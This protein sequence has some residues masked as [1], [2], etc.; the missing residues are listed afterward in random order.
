[1]IRHLYLHVPFCSGKC[2]YCGFYSVVRPPDERERY[3]AALVRELDHRATALSAPLTSLYLGGGTPALL[4]VGGF[5]CLATALRT[6]GL[7]EAS[8][9]WTVELHPGS[10]EPAFL[11]ALRAVGV[12]RISLGAQS[13]DD[14]VLRRLGRRHDAAAVDRA[15]GAVRQTGFSDYGLDLIAGLPGV[16]E[17]SWRSSLARAVDLGCTHLSVYAL[18]VEDGTVLRRQVDQGLILPGSDAQLDALATA[19]SMLAAAGLERYEISNYARPGRACRHNLA[20]WRGED[21]LG[22]GPSAASRMGRRRWT[23]RPDLDV[24]REA[25]ATGRKPPRVSEEELSAE[26]DAVE[27]FVFAVRLAEGVSPAGF[28]RSHPAALPRVAAW[29]D[30]LD[31][32]AKTGIVERLAAPEGRWRLTARGREV[33]DAVIRELL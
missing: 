28:A 16:T 14:A 33:A 1:M 4:G 24:W 3:A 18:G 17:A 7:L 25:V 21:Y 15:I 29:E 2:I 31:R 12:N 26:E 19:E 9:E 20:V 13:F 5:H 22:L 30:C 6:R 8:V 10:C 32:L 27:R 11:E 23:N